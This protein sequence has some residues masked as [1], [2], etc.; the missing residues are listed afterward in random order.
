MN[1]SLR[2][3]LFPALL[4]ISACASNPQP[5]I[6]TDL[7]A[8]QQALAA[9]QQWTVRGRAALTLD[10]RA[11]QLGF[12]W[13]Q[14]RELATLTLSG[15]IGWGRYQLA[16]NLD[17]GETRLTEGFDKLDDAERQ[18]IANRLQTLPMAQLSDWL[19]GLCT[20]CGPDQTSYDATGMVKSY[21][22]DRWQVSYTA[23]QNANALTLPR[24]LSFSGPQ[25]E[26]KL[27]LK[28]WQLD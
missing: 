6:P 27:L 23:F 4:V 18:A 8:N 19:L 10:G 3:L 7:A 20:D 15:P 24:R 28:D 25:T 21:Q 26:G 16:Y 9:L 2:A 14:N 22:N 17:S 1:S 5:A 13:Q 11:E 12:Y